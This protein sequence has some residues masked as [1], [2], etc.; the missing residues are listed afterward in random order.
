MHQWHFSIL[1]ESLRGLH[2]ILPEALSSSKASAA[3]NPSLRGRG[4]P[5]R[6]EPPISDGGRALARASDGLLR[7]AAASRGQRLGDGRGEEKKKRKKK[8]K[9]PTTRLPES[10]Y[11]RERRASRA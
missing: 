7:G 6:R 11:P 10:R 2:Q 5:L 8:K 9:E 1:G 4:R 3:A